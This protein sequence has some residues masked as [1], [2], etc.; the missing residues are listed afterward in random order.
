MLSELQWGRGLVTTE[1]KH[2][3]SRDEAGACFNGAVAW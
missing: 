3:S 2:R 1:I